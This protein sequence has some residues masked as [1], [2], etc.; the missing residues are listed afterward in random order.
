MQENISLW[1]NFDLRAPTSTSPNCTAENVLVR[2][3]K[4]LE[5]VSLYPPLK[6]ASKG[7][8]NG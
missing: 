4:L 8:K 6:K 7:S 5:E 1:G 2:T 3:K